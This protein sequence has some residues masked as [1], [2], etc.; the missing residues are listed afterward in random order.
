[1]FTICYTSTLHIFIKAICYSYNFHYC[2]QSRSYGQFHWMYGWHKPLVSVYK[3]VLV[4]I[5]K[6]HDTTLV[7]MKLLY[8]TWL[9][10]SY[11]WI[12]SLPAP[13]E[14]CLILSDI[15]S[16]SIWKLKDKYF[17]YY[18]VWQ[19]FECYCMILLL[20]DNYYWC[21]PVHQSWE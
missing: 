17:Y 1:M 19:F 18:F 14:T 6:F 10:K 16:F 2:K 7:M 4:I 21:L 12:P 11:M 20:V 13:C 9:I 3:T 5:I 15:I 8:Y